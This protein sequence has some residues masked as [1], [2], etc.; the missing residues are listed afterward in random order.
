MVRE[1]RRRSGERS[2]MCNIYICLRP[3]QDGCVQGTGQGRVMG[4]GR[5]KR[6]RKRNRTGGVTPAPLTA[7]PLLGISVH[8]FSSPFP[9]NETRPCDCD[10]R[11]FARC[12]SNPIFMSRPVVL[13][14]PY[15]HINIPLIGLIP[16]LPFRTLD[17]VVPSH[18]PVH[19]EPGFIRRMVASHPRSQE[20]GTL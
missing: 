5:K 15:P 9:S 10:P 16:F 11:L 13:W 12:T 20:H 17:R 8:H 7:F 1:R 3:R 14:R 4:G 6:E 18:P 19:P 2:I